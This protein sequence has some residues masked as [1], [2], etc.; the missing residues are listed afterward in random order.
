VRTD[1]PP[2]EAQSLVP[3][4][5]KVASWQQVTNVVNSAL[6]GAKIELVH[7]P[8]AE[9]PVRADEIYFTIEPKGA[10]WNEI[11]RDRAIALFLPKPFEPRHT[12][13]SLL[14][15]PPRGE[16]PRAALR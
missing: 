15:L 4:I 1:V 9:V 16:A 5:G 10:Y 13:V 12:K 7:R 14:A 8:P 6:P 2:R 3:T 11:H